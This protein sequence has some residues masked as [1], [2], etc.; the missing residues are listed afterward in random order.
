[1]TRNMIAELFEKICYFKTVS[2]NGEYFALMHYPVSVKQII[3]FF[4]T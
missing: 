1:M 3:E 4:N 2:L